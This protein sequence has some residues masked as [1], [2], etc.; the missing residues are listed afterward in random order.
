MVRNICKSDI[1]LNHWGI[2]YVVW[3]MKKLF[4]GKLIFSDV[5]TDSLL[6]WDMLSFFH[7][8]CKVIYSCQSIIT[9]SLQFTS[10]STYFSS[11]KSESN[12]FFNSFRLATSRSAF[13]VLWYHCNSNSSMVFYVGIRKSPS[14]QNK[15]YDY[16][17][18]VADQ[19]LQWVAFASTA[20][21]AKAPLKLCLLTRWQ[22]DQPVPAKMFRSILLGL[23]MF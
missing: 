4:G 15:F 23:A 2:L 14:K 20:R 1:H 16:K 19:S 11:L 13:L 17:H 22:I 18:N 8:L 7:M 10:F 21:S 6:L 5:F 3:T 9:P 12:I